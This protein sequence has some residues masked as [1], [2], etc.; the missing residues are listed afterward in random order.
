VTVSPTPTAS[1][2]GQAVVVCVVENP[3]SYKATTEASCPSENSSIGL[4]ELTN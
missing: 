1:P 3:C 4:P 2:T